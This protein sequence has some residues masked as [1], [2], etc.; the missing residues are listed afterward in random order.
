MKKLKEIYFII[1]A[2]GAGKTTAVKHIEKTNPNDFQSK[3]R[4][5]Y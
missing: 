4:L 2:S 5:F 3:E 1:G